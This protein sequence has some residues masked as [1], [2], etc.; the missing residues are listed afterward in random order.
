MQVTETLSEGLKRQLRVVVP[1]AELERRLSQQLD[2]LKTRVNLKGFRPGKVPVAHLRKVYGKSVMADVI[3]K[4]VNETSRQIVEEREEKP[5]FQP[6]ITLPQEKDEVEAVLGGQ[7]DLAFGMEFEILPVF[8]IADLS[9]L[10]LEREVAEVEEAEIDAALERITRQN[11]P[12]EP[13]PEAEAAQNGDRLTIDFVGRID[14]EVFEGG[15]A[16]D[17]TL[18]LGSGSFIPGFEE[19]LVGAKPGETRTVKVTFPENY[20]AEQLAGKEAEFEVTVKQVAAPGEVTLDDAFA[21]SLG[22]ESLEALRQAIRQQIE[23]EYGMATRNRIKRQL[24]DKLDEAHKFELPPSLVDQ[25]FEGIWREVQRDLERAGRSFEDEDTT[26]EKAREDYRGIAERRVRLGLVLAKV[27]E[28]AQIKVTDEEMQRALMT[29]ARQFPGQER[30]VFEF[31]QKNP[32]ALMELRAPIYEDK[33]V[34][35]IV[36][37]AQVTDRQVSK[38]ELLRDE[39]EHGHGHD[40]DHD[41]AHDHDHHHDHD[42]AHDHDHDHGHQHG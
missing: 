8:E 4:A 10:T 9:T 20:G 29:R 19:Q 22:I 27:G 11:R 6:R 16:E 5:A 36:S 32:G 39:E 34:D 42:H 3:E 23:S 24:L 17:A 38:E 28:Q 7:Q 40:H 14:G 26:E 2:E 1:A 13:R 15:S 21:Q 35:H 25:E 30:A 37:Q 12:F 41:H 31:Y 33:V 18:E